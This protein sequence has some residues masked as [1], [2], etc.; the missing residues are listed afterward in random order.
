LES[1]TKIEGD[2][3]HCYS[4][5]QVNQQEH[6]LP[7]VGQV[8]LIPLD[9]NT[10]SSTPAHEMRNTRQGAMVADEDEV[11]MLQQIMETTRVLQQAIEDHRREQDR[12]REEAQ[13]EQERL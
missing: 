4:P 8:K 11:P 2:N 1:A 9:T 10:S 13:I 5:S 12:L 3:N 6:L 7:T